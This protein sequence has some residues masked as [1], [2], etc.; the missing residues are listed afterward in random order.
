MMIAAAIAWGAV[1]LILA[2]IAPIESVDTGRAGV[3]PMRSLVA[4]QGYDV[5]PVAA[6]P[7]VIAIVV[8]ILLMTMPHA[9]W[10]ATIAWILSGALLLA[11][12]AGAVTFLIGIYVLP[13]CVLLIAAL[14]QAT[15]GRRGTPSAPAPHPL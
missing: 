14:S 8:G 12:L 6:I 4:V 11:S 10:A 3:Q 1:I 7:L 2:V 15:S 13:T 5:L 9:R